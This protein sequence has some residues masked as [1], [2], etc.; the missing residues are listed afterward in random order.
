M[1]C[2][3]LGRG[4]FNLLIY[5]NVCRF[6]IPDPP[7]SKGPTIELQKKI[8]LWAVKLPSAD[9]IVVQRTLGALTENPGG[10]LGR[11]ESDEHIQKREVFW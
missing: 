2:A 4:E 7:P 11:N 5:F 8:G 1:A 9:A 3:L 6:F 10:L